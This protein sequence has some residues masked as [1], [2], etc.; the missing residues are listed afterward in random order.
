MST[1]DAGRRASGPAPAGAELENAIGVVRAFL[2]ALEARNLA[3]ARSL[4]AADVRIVVPGGRELAAVEE[5][6]ANSARRYR[7]IGKHIQRFDALAAPEGGVTV[8]CI[9]TLHGMWADGVAFD[10]VRFI[11]RF[12]LAGGRIRL[13]EV[14]ND[15]AERRAAIASASR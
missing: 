3:D 5:I 9:G 4:L 8:Y 14:W 11:D 12:E 15:A 6:A 1:A 7:R 2:A 10:D 13:Q